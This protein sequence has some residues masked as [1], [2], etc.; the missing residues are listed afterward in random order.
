MLFVADVNI[1]DAIT[2]QQAVKVARGCFPKARI[3]YLCNKWSGD[4]VAAI[5]G[6]DHVYAVFEGSGT[7]S[8]EDLANIRDIIR[9][10]SYSVI[11]NLCPFLAKRELQI[12]GPVFQLYRPMISYIIRLWKLKA[13]RLHISYTLYTFLGKLLTPFC[14]AKE[15]QDL[16]EAGSPAFDSFKGNSIYLTRDAISQAEGF[17]ATHD[18]LGA[19]RLLFFNPNAASPYAQMPMELQ[20]QVLKQLSGSE[21]INGVLL[22]TGHSDRSIERTIIAMLPEV[23]RT[24]VVVVPQISLGVYAALI[25]AC[26]LFLS[27]DTGPVHISASW[28]VALSGNDSLRNRTAIVTV[29]GASDSRMY[30]YDSEQ[31]HHMPANQQAPS[32]AFSA[33]APCRNIMC[34]NKLGKSCEEV[35]CFTGLR[36]QDIS[37]YVISYFRKLRDQ[38]QGQLEPSKPLRGAM[39]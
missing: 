6:A 21:Y 35:R 27:S 16:S 13:D 5:P 39:R 34:I 28:K 1:G 11:F 24:K 26:D 37:G 10:G 22:G 23:Y 15:I 18:L 30:G 36:A 9:R 29:F 38:G 31:P 20:I 25:D 12:R 2:N 19:R 7:P 17:L 32:K 4:L 33:P 14:E 3:D 8:K